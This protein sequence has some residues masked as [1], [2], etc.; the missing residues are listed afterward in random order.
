LVLLVAGCDRAP[1]LPPDD[2]ATYQKLTG[3]DGQA[4]LRQI[5]SYDWDDGGQSAAA[6][7]S[8]IAKDALSANEAAAQRAGEAAHAIATFLAEDRNEDRDPR[9]VRAYASALTPFQGA[10]VGDVTGVRGF[11]PIGDPTGGDLSSARQIVAAI[12]SN[13]DAGSDFNDAGDQR[14]R[15]YLHTYAQAI[16]GGKTDGTVALRYAADLAGVLAGGQRESGNSAIQP[17]TAQHWINWAGYELAA[18]MGARPG[19]PDIPDRFFTS[20]GQLKSPDD[21]S[22]DELRGFSTAVLNF[23]FSHGAPTL[24]TDF[25]DWYDAAAGK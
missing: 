9:L 4:F 19:G 3:D 2:P 6:R 15:D 22:K 23:A 13:T 11:T 14:V 18:A 1:E 5:S 8:W 17:K 10:L 7:F 24:A 21:V 16:A 12:D 20:E 25:N